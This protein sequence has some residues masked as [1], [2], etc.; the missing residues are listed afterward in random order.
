[1]QKFSRGFNLCGQVAVISSD[2]VGVARQPAASSLEELAGNN[3]ASPL[4]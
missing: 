3:G 4:K 1:V 2:E